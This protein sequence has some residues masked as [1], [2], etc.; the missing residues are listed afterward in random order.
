MDSDQPKGF[1][2]SLTSPDLIREHAN[3]LGEGVIMPLLMD[4][5]QLR[6]SESLGTRAET[7]ICK[8]RSKH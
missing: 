5:M 8:R 1:D 6:R 4:R 7:S 2:S 3:S